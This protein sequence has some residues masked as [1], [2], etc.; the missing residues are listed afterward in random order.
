MVSSLKWRV[1]TGYPIHLAMND[2]IILIS[3]STISCYYSHGEEAF[4]G[5]TN[6]TNAPVALQWV[7][8]PLPIPPP[9]SHPAAKNGADLF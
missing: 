9:T 4:V 3:N 2:Q 1:N 8:M 7:R 5:R 6:V